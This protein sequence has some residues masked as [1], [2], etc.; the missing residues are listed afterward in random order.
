MVVDKNMSKLI[1]DLE[2][3][4]GKE[5]FNTKSYDVHC[6]MYGLK[7]RYPVHLP[8]ENN[9]TFPFKENINDFEA[10]VTPENVT[11]MKYKFGCNQLYIGQG[12]INILNYLEQRY[13][14]DFNELESNR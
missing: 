3:C 14:L 10:W 7:F 2:Y 6:K 5:C 11:K 13:D 9:E 4:V 8:D 12:I 1:G